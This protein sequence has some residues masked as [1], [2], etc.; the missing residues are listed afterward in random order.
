MDD[1]IFKPEPVEG[2][3]YTHTNGTTI[4][5]TKVLAT[6]VKFRPVDFNAKP[7]V[8]TYGAKPKAPADLKMSLKQWDIDIKGVADV[9]IP[10]VGELY[11]EPSTWEGDPMLDAERVL[12]VENGSVEYE[13]VS[14]YGDQP[15]RRRGGGNKIPVVDYILGRRRVY[16]P[17]RNLEFVKGG[18]YRDR[19][20]SVIEV[21]DTKALGSSTRPGAVKYVTF[22]VNGDSYEYEEDPRVLIGAIA[23]PTDRSALTSGAIAEADYTAQVSD[24]LSR[25]QKAEEL[26]NEA[27]QKAEAVAA[28]VKAAKNEYTNALAG[29][30]TIG[31]GQAML[32]GVAA[33][34]K[35][36][37]DAPLYHDDDDEGDDE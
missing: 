12:A 10:Q 20:G 2:R 6:A 18:V 9:R 19:D 3:F 11:R 23:A 16:E 36:G 31:H 1:I 22:R 34:V 17:K 30:K 33:A 7:K 28:K 26:V 37:S 25:F 5:V 21:L 29:L 4:L 13:F 32:P 8:K 35:R 24:A 27:T 15:M 14:S